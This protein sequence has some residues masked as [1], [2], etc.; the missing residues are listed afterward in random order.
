MVDVTDSKQVQNMV[1]RAI[2]EFGRVD[3]LINNAALLRAPLTPIWDM[4]DE[5]WNY[6]ISA[7]LTGAFYCIR[8]LS[9]QMAE[10]GWG[11]IINIAS[12]YGF[13]GGRNMFTYTSGKGGMVQLTRSLA[14]SLGPMGVT[15]NT[16][17]PAFIPTGV[18]NNKRSSPPPNPE[19]T[20]MGRF[21]TPSEL[22]PLAVFL[23]SR[24]SGY[25]NGGNINV[26]GASMA[27]G[28]APN[29]YTPNYSQELT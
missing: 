14:L 23:A 6:G 19:F 26:D 18:D 28:F 13:R 7:N 2:Q 11:R 12:Q 24:A 25:I 16:V 1:D 22:G 15:C 4:T 27:G 20:P 29:G 10:R 3:V 9:R 5:E 21:P 8:S 17:S